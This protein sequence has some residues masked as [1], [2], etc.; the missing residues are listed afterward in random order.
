MKNPSK[1]GLR[2]RRKNSHKPLFECIDYTAF[3]K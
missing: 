2:Q 3:N 1:N